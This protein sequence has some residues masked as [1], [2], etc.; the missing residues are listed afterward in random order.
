MIIHQMNV[1]TAFLNATLQEEIYMIPPAGLTAIKPGQVLKL[2]KS[3]YGLEQSPCN[4]N[5]EIND[6]LLSLG[7]TR[8]TT[9]TCI[10]VKTVNGNDMYVAIYVD[11][12]IIACKDEEP[13]E[14][15]K[16]QLAS[17]YKVK[18]MGEMDWYL[19]MRYTRD[20]TT[21]IITLDQS[22]YAGNVL[23]R[24]KGLCKI[25]PH[26]STSM[27]ENLRLHKWTESYDATLSAKSK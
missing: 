15:V 13:I 4:F 20:P 27:N 26:Y 14:E 1:D 7:F 8:C 12:I 10:Y 6:T 5:L 18:D 9:D 24:F 22:K 11:D 25:S 19:G 16:A 23:T 2:N 21:G 17:K 3:L